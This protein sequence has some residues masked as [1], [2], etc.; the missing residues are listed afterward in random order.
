MKTF[1]AAVS[2]STCGY[3]ELKA[4][5]AAAARKLVQHI[6]ASVDF[7]SADVDSSMID[8]PVDIRVDAIEEVEEDEE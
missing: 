4:E 1:Q 6:E 8:F 3:L 7:G 5:D 2:I